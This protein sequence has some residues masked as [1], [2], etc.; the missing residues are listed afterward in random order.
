MEFETIDRTAC[1]LRRSDGI[2]H[3]FEVWDDRY[4]QPDRF[5]LAYCSSGDFAFL[6][7]AIAS[8]EMGRL[9]ERY[10]LSHRVEFRLG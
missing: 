1:P 5:P 10:Y 4:G 6:E 3:M 9:Y 8:H 2:S 7:K